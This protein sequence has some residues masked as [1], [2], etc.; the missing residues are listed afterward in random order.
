MDNALL[1]ITRS[2]KSGLIVVTKFTDIFIRRPV[3]AIVVSLLILVLG[4]NAL[5]H[6]PIQQYPQMENT[7]IKV[8]TNYP[9]AN[10]SVIEGF[11]SSPI[12]KLVAS[13]DGVDYITSSS[14]LGVSTINAYIK[15]NFD[16]NAA[17]TSVMSQ[18]NQAR[19]QL[20]RDAQPSII[21]KSTG[22]QV[23]LMY[24]SFSSPT[25]TRPQITDYINRVVQP[26]LQT[27]SGVSQV[28]I[29]GSTVSAMRIWLKPDRLAALNVT[30]TDIGNALQ[31][32][33][34]ISAAGNTK[35]VLVAYT[36][37]PQTNLHTVSDFENIVIKHNGASL[38]YLK[39]V[40]KVALGAQNYNSDV[41]FNGKSAV[42]IGITATPTANPLSVI[43]QI[44]AKLPQ[45]QQQYPPGLSSNVVYDVTA[46]I[47]ASM[48]E[49]IKTI[50]EAS[51]IVILV[52][53]V[54]LGSIRSVLIPVVTIPLSL[55]G[56]CTFMY[57]FGFSINLLTLLAMVLA[58]GLVV[59]DAIVVVENI[60]RHIES[61]K[62]PLEASILGAREIATAVIAMTITLA[63]VYAPIGFMGGL[64]GAL[65]KEFAFTLA[66][67]VIISG[68][69]ALTLSPMMCSK[70]LKQGDAT[71]MTQYVDKKFET[72][73]NH[74]QSLLHKVLN[75]RQSVLLVAFSILLSIYFL[76]RY[77]ASEL[78]PVEDQSAIFVQA[79]APAYANIDYTNKY[80][81]PIQA[82]FSQFPETENYFL[83]NGTDSPNVIFGGTILKAWNQR[84]RGQDVILPQLQQKLDGLPGLIAAAFPL[85]PLPVAGNTLPIQFIISTTNGFGELY[86]TSQKVLAEARQSGMFVYIN[87]TLRFDN[88][89]LNIAI[90]TDKAGAMGL[91]RNDIGAALSYAL[92]GNYINYFDIEGQSYQ[93]IPQVLRQ[94]R[95]NPDQLL[96]IYIQTVQ[97]LPIPLST[98]AKIK[99]VVQPS[100]LSHF[101]QLNSATI[102][103]M[104]APGKTLGEGLTTLQ[105]VAAKILP[106]DYKVDYAGQSRQYVQEGSALIITFF[107]AIVIIFL[108]L[109]AQ[110]E[111]FRDPLIILVTV[112][113]SICGALIFLNIG[114]ASINIYTQIGLVTLIGLI[115]KHGI[116]MVDFANHLRRNDGLDRRQA[117][118]QAAGIRLRPILMTTG[119]MVLGLLPLLIAS[120]AG[121]KSRF[122]IGLVIV[123]GM[124][125][126]TLFTLFV[127]PTIYTLL[128]QSDAA[129]AVPN[130]T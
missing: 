45:M 128:A 32:N 34:F 35:G 9:G 73:K 92:G 31:K 14:T 77:T 57:A 18:A 16:P 59:D 83:V 115:S 78:A 72:F 54:F 106:S 20:P 65:F 114:L 70:L 24:M 13:A 52:I 63:A 122:D 44:K 124:L 60:H 51:C 100:N 49:V 12:E 2:S 26:Q 39:D 129:D 112:P 94:F 43:D 28:Q 79:T 123:A 71:A 125:I 84:H 1:L 90:D 99:K 97:G 88:P 121:A 107:L 6:L 119:A 74:Y 25:I 61:G 64:T 93:V 86:E 98:I 80:T 55:I 30:P 10:P 3:L 105:H 21:Q 8:I 15:L 69:V 109:A 38:V 56:V 33:N 62:T 67:S 58:I 11:I 23:A 89:Q 76:Y 48:D 36:I 127:L 85:P 91:S 113:M 19:A 82:I 42:F 118:E 130:N 104:I 75:E 40:A 87:N 17:F 50:L 22:S 110:F 66:G 108:V 29:L 4:L 81:K 111:S 27:V 68:I 37:N 103:A 126:G 101:Q 41:T 116:L 120:G 53:F 96:N 7:L 117:I 46:Y 102:E 47:R 5:Y 95:M